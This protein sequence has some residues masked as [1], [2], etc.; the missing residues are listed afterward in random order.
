M[1]STEVVDVTARELSENVVSEN[2][3]SGK[4][5]SCNAVSEN[6]AN[7]SVKLEKKYKSKKKEPKSKKKEPEYISQFVSVEVK[8]LSTGRKQVKK[9][10][11]AL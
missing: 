8:E 1:L 11:P 6:I 5:V 4:I 9:L 3:V 7:D 10:I 2:A